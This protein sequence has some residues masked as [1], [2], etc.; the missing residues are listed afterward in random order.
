MSQQ[1]LEVTLPVPAK[2]IDQ[3]CDTLTNSGL[4]GLVV[5][6]E[7]EAPPPPAPPRDEVPEDTPSWATVDEE[8]EAPPPPAPPRPP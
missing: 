4:T 2:L 6:E 7:G 3:V 8:G 1:W 5:E